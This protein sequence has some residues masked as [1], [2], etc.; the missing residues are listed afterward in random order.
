M[1]ADLA[2]PMGFRLSENLVSKIRW[3]AMEEDA[4]LRPPWTDTCT[5]IHR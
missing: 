5:H 4:A 3:R 2:K 1:T